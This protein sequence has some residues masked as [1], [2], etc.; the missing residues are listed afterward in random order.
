MEE[1]RDVLA[2]EFYGDRT[3]GLQAIKIAH[4]PSRVVDAG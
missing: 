3:R 2:A 1:E 4:R